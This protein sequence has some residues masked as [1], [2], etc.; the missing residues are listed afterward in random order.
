MAQ[1]KGELVA[2]QAEVFQAFSTVTEELSR[3]ASEQQLL[4]VEA[5]VLE[6]AAA[7]SQQIEAEL[8]EKIGQTEQE[9]AEIIAALQTSYNS[10]EQLLE[11][12][13]IYLWS[14]R[15]WE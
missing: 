12:L 9:K 6:E 13:G 15:M 8:Q 4:L 10:Q 5:T 14:L 1:A 2:E 3:L 7:K 11:R